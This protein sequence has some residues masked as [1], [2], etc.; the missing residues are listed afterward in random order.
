MPNKFEHVFSLGKFR[1]QLTE[2]DHDL[3]ELPGWMFENVLL[4]AD[5]QS[6]NDS[7]GATHVVEPNDLKEFDFRMKH[8]VN[9]ARFAGAAIKTDVANEDI[10]H[11]L[12][13]SDKIR[14]K[15]LREKISKHVF[16]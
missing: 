9:T 6:F 14:V 1:K 8:A 2:H 10:T 3:G 16:L 15:N 11:M 4:Y 12:V 7:D 13:G 5:S